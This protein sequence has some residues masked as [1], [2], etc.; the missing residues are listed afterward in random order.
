MNSF[1][2]SLNVSELNISKDI[3]KIDTNIYPSNKNIEYIKEKNEKILSSNNTTRLSLDN[4][5]KKENKII[6][7]TSTIDNINS[8]TLKTTFPLILTNIPKNKNIYNTTLENNKVMESSYK[9]KNGKSNKTNLSLA[10]LQ[11]ELFREK[12]RKNRNHEINELAEEIM[13]P[14]FLKT[15]NTLSI[16]NKHEK[17]IKKINLFKPIKTNKI[18]IDINKNKK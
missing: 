4:K 13:R 5:N 11:K 2:R 6:N 1:K 10:F 8:Y 3:S 14:T 18:L 12:I 15:N 7:R 17:E 16:N 9:K